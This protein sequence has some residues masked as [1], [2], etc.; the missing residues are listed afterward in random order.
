MS[1]AKIVAFYLPAFYPF[2]ENNEFWGEGFTEWDFV[3]RAQPNFQ[4]H[5]QP[6]I[7]I[8][9]YTEFDSPEFLIKQMNLAKTYSITAF[10]IYSYWFG[11]NRVMTR[12]FDYLAAIEET[13]IDFCIAWANE[14][15]NRRWD[16][17]EQELLIEKKHDQ[18][19]D[20]N[21]IDDHYA[22]LNHPNYLRIDGKLALL[23]YR[24][25]LMDAPKTTIRNLR[26]RARE[27]GLGE[28]KL[29]MVQWFEESD[30]RP[31]D[32]DGSVQFPPTVHKRKH[33]PLGLHP[34]FNGTVFDYDDV[35]DLYLGSKSDF[36]EYKGVMPDWDNTPRR[37]RNEFEVPSL[38]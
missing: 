29:L 13:P 8:D 3:K 26:N 36:V 22:I 28:L 25:H 9:G 21:F 5:A 20:A 11:G 35:I 24:P 19:N 18:I 15:W 37:L 10:C 1:Q 16:G 32:F 2:K 17:R 33:Y 38:S 6:N 27:L 34:D 30:P 23:I 12:A 31:F 7:P 4:G 14:N